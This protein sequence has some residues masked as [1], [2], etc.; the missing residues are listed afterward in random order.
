VDAPRRRTRLLA[1]ALALVVGAAG[2]G[3]LAGK[4]VKSPGDAAA[5]RKPPAAS[6]VT[7]P[8]E[9]R[10][11]AS[12]VTARGT[13]RYEQPLPVTLAGAVGGD[14][15]SGGAT[16]VTRAPVKGGDLKEAD[17]AIEVSGRPVLVL[18]G[19]LPMYRSITPGT[20]GRD[21]K[22]LE[23]AL[24]RLGIDPGPVDG[25]FDATTARAIE[26]LYFNTGYAVQGASKEQ[27]DQ[28]RS[29]RKAAT[30]AD[31]NARAAQRRYDEAA[32]G[33]TGSAL[34]ELQNA[35][36]DSERGVVV[37]AADG[38]QTVAVAQ[39]QIATK[40]QDLDVSRSQKAQ[41]DEQLSRAVA[42]G[43]DPTAPPAPCPAVCI[44]RL[45]T[46][47]TAADSTVGAAASAV[48]VARSGLVT[49]QRTVERNNAQAASALELARQRLADAKN[50]TDLSAAKRDRDAAATA[51][52][53][54]NQEAATF[55]KSIGTTIPAGEIAFFPSLPV[56]IDDVKVKAGDSISGQF[57]T[58]SGS[59]LRVEAAVPL[60]DIDNVKTG[61]AVE[62]RANDLGLKL[63]GVIAEIADKPGTRGVDARS[64]AVAITPDD[65]TQ[66]AELNGASVA[67][68]IPVQST[69]GKAVLTVPVA[70]LVTKADGTTSVQVAKGGSTNIADAVIV[71]VK[72]GLSA[73]GYAQIDP[74][75]GASLG[76]GDRV[77]VGTK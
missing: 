71:P 19:E 56:R 26:I 48:E 13:I 4:R 35:V 45:Q 49:A 57:M 17:V 21:V 31:E 22:Q 46:A 51:A 61:A 60:V 37:A 64:V 77:V 27:R 12:T 28:L 75:G 50:P 59:K 30:D 24:A 63:T 66:A 10:V 55:D 68:V 39:S 23:E 73:G 52:V 65:L 33:V 42:T 70:A 2:I 40:Q 43:I 7:V 15:T 29:L 34:L 16:Q 44:T 72:V 69:G 8:V 62:I 14:G 1:G 47:V 36:G 6:L 25:V 67:V 11:L 9:E 74:I 58:V 76:K 18:E 20:S 38:E 3:W 41:A 54:A 32:R 5:A 53:T